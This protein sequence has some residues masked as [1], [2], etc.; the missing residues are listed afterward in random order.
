MGGQDLA[1]AI[2]TD[3]C[4]DRSSATSSKRGRVW[5]GG[6]DLVDRGGR[7]LLVAYSHDDVRAWGRQVLA[8]TSLSP[9]LA[10][11][12]TAVRPVWSGISAAVQLIS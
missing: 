1:G 6:P 2:F 8:V 10:P 4:D 12:T 11:V 3:A 7:L 9:P 5:D